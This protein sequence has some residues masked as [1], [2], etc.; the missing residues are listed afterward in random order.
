MHQITRIKNL[1]RGA[2]AALLIAVGFFDSAQASIASICSQLQQNLD[3]FRTEN[4][5]SGMGLYISAPHHHLCYLFSGTVKKEAKQAITPN[6]LWQIGSVSKSYFAAILLQLEAQSEAGQISVEFN[7]NQTLKQWLPQYPDW[8]NVTIKQL[9]NMTSGIYNYTDFPISQMILKN[10][11]KVWTTD[12]IIQLAYQHQPNT[13]FAPG[14]GWHYSDTNYILAGELIQIIVQKSTGKTVP[15]NAILKQQ[16]LYPLALKNSDYD[17]DLLP[18]HLAS[19]MVHGYN[20]YSQKDFTAFNLSIAGPAGGMISN[21]KDVADWVE[22]LLNGHLLP[23]K[24][25]DE[26]QALVSQKTGLPIQASET[27]AVPAYSLGLAEQYSKKW[28]E[29]WF[30]QGVTSGY[31][32]IYFYLPQSDTIVSFT[33]SIGSIRN[34]PIPFSAFAKTVLQVI[35]SD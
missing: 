27:S 18:Q 5:I 2:L 21:P 15:L 3:Q 11:Q 24:Q 30:Y 6:N 1:F 9:L 10:P 31:S 12:E 4:N 16:L 13:Y 33:A 23:K 34:N 14:M 29:V 17:P 28:G 32:T 22:I 7:I 20:Y 8:G 35:L 25:Q 19:R 26:I